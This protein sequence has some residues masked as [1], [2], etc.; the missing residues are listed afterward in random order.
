[1][2]ISELYERFSQAKEW[3]RLAAV[4][5][6]KVR[7]IILRPHG[8]TDADSVTRETLKGWL[9]ES[10][11]P[12]EDTVPTESVINHMMIW[13]KRWRE[14]SY[15]SLGADSN[16]VAP[17]P[18][19]LN[20]VQK[21]VG[22]KAETLRPKPVK[23]A[24]TKPNVA[25][26]ATKRKN[27]AEIATKKPKKP[28]IKVKEEKP[29]P[30]SK[31]HTK[32]ETKYA[33]RHPE[34]LDALEDYADKHNI[35]IYD[36]ENPHGGRR[37]TGTIYHDNASK[38]Y[39]ATGKR[40]FKDCWRAE[41]MIAGQRYRH[42][43]KDRDDCVAWLKA[44]KQGK[45]KPTDNK[46]DW[47]RMEQRK[48]ES[49]RIDEIIVSQAEEAVMLYDYHQSG[50]LSK[51]NEYLTMRLLPHM[52]YYA[53]HTLH[54]GKDSTITA[55][56]QAA[57]LLLTRI[58]AN[59]PVLNF[60]ATCKRMMRVYKQ[61]GDFFYYETAPQEVKLMVNKINFDGLAEVW[62]VTKDRRI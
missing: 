20:P 54:L 9:S 13:S 31:C 22:K 1:M 39:D 3:Q 21:E 27:T 26:S 24:K 23:K 11:R 10:K 45:I 52:M 14:Q 48:D 32:P 30:V 17:A 53:A 55:S 51:I 25:K 37:S 7:D 5:R 47:W 38:G 15:K 57:G 44:V 35:N 4:M 16:K 46:A 6:G 2:T 19:L 49:V 59:R 28:I 33:T 62:K 50:D 41:I 43:S 34:H 18:S 12:M 29:K 8:D 61:R 60:T 58:T 56:R 40:V 36:S 42:R